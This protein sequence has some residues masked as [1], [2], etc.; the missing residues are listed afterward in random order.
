MSLGLWLYSL[1]LTCPELVSVPSAEAALDLGE[2]GLLRTHLG[3]AVSADAPPELSRRLVQGGFTASTRGSWRVHA[4]AFLPED[5]ARFIR[6]LAHE[7]EADASPT[8]PSFHDHV[9]ALLHWDDFTPPLGGSGGTKPT[10]VWTLLGARTPELVDALG[11]LAAKDARFR[12]HTPEVP[13]RKRRP[14]TLLIDQRGATTA[15]L[16]IILTSSS[17]LALQAVEVVAAA[18]GDGPHSRL[19]RA[20][21]SR[22]PERAL[23]S[24]SVHDAS[25]SALALTLTLPV[26]EVEAAVQTLVEQL[27]VLDRR[28]LGAE[29]F[30]VARRRAAHR[31][32]VAGVTAAGRL[33]V[34]LLDHLRHGRGVTPAEVECLSPVAVGTALRAL[35][36]LSGLRL[37]LEADVPVELGAQLARRWPL[38]EVELRARP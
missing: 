35:S 10:W 23:G 12:P 15:Q 27:Q 19:G 24:L 18:L 14:R 25:P 21:R 22:L 29:E 13:P 8:E 28:G 3:I 34:A 9:D 36:P 2:P 38:G 1:L 6:A 7:M 37:V 32:A 26:S 31:R 30:E 5:A 11:A 4:G 20:L 17:A 16:A 33:E